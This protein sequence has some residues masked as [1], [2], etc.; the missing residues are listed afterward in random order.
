MNKFCFWAIYNGR[1]W[2][3]EL[4]VSAHKGRYRHDSR[5]EKNPYRHDRRADSLSQTIQI[6]IPSPPAVTAGKNCQFDVSM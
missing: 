6:Q 4:R 3:K 2:E 1:L 5:A